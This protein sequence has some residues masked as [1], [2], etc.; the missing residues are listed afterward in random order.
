VL[1]RWLLGTH[2]GAVRSHDLDAYLDESVFRFNRRSSGRVTLPFQRLCAIVVLTAPVTCTRI[3]D[4]RNCWGLPDSSGE[5]LGENRPS[6]VFS[7][8]ARVSGVQVIGP[9]A[10]KAPDPHRLTRA[11][12]CTAEKRSA[13][14]SATRLRLRRG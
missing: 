1:K 11:L 5:P 9:A 6:P 10:V 13:G 4:D 3:V 12:G 2:Q 14:L 7:F 8:P